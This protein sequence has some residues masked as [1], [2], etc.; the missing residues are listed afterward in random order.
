LVEI[1]LQRTGGNPYFV[2][3]VLR[4]LADSGALDV[5]DGQWTWSFADA[6][7]V[8]P[9]VITQILARRMDHLDPSVRSALDAASVAGFEF[10]SDVVAAITVLGDDTLLDLL[11]AAVR[12]GIVDE[13]DE[14]PGAYRFAHPLA[15]E[16]LYHSL[17][18]NRR[19]QL[20]TRAGE[21]IERLRDSHDS[22][23]VRE[24]ARHYLRGVQDDR[25]RTIT[26]AYRAA[27]LALAARAY[28]EAM[29]LCES[30]LTIAGEDHP[31]LRRAVLSIRG[32]AIATITSEWMHPQKVAVITR[33]S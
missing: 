11:D 4:D 15:W 27:E 30:A 5:R 18:A 9:D 33:P 10:D 20:H 7:V 21:A 12:S 24:L 26:H 16:V 22:H 25:R 32:V 28:D 17:T 6:R 23:V 8:I 29:E 19:A 1:L 2:L 14:R 31:E 3:E 13:L